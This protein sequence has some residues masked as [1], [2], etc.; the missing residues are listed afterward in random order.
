MTEQEYLDRQTLKLT[1]EENFKFFSRYAKKRKS[2]K[3]AYFLWLIGGVF[4]LHRIYLRR[5]GTAL[6]VFGVTVFTGGIG[7]VAGLYDVTNIKRITFEENH[8]LILKT[9]KEV[10]RK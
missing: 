7:A 10:K 3:V 6:I 8:E 4:G 1:P 5:Y 9:M 2:L